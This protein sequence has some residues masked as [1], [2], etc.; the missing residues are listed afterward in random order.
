[1]KFPGLSI[2]KFKRTISV[3]LPTANYGKQIAA[4]T[5]RL[6]DIFGTLNDKSGITALASQLTASLSTLV[7]Q[8]G[9]YAAQQD[10]VANA[11]AL[12]FELNSSYSQIADLRQETDELLKQQTETVN[13]LL[14]SIKD[15]DG[16]IRDATLSNVSTAEM[17]D[18]RDRLVEQLSGYL[19]VTVSKNEDNTLFILTKDSQQLYSDG[20]VSTLSFAPTNHLQPGQ[21]GNAVYAT[22]P[23]G[24][25]F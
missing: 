6:D 23:G 2:H 25:R 20:Q 8:P 24:T 15:I 17:E 12:A 18:E 3:R 11:K 21:P 10:V 14:T 5:D 19:D 16:S 22:T 7:N 13:N 4:F 1:M 9:N